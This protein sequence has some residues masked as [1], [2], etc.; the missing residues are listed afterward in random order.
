MRSSSIKSIVAVLSISV[1]VLA[2]VPTATARPAQKSQKS[3]STRTR[4]VAP[5]TDRFTSMR[6]L[7]NR[8]LRRLDLNG[9]IGIPVPRDE[10]PLDGT[11]PSQPAAP[12][13]P[14]E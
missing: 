6:D 11:Q 9:R 13:E 2:A 7:I 5:S 1:T 8:T 4:E 10:E 3:Q 14:E 12:S